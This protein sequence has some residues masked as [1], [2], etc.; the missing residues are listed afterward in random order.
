[1]QNPLDRIPSVRDVEAF[2]SEVCASYSL[3]NYVEHEV[4]EKG[5]EDCNIRLAT[6]TEAYL[7]KVFA[8][9]RKPGEAQR[10]VDILDHVLGANVAHP[11]L[12]A[13]S[14][15]KH[16]GRTGEVDHLVMDFLDGATLA[17]RSTSPTT[18]QLRQILREAA[19]IHAIDYAPEEHYDFWA[20]PNLLA[21]TSEI[22][23]HLDE[24][25]SQI[26]ESARSFHQSIPFG[27]LPTRLIHGD[28]VP[29][30]V[31]LTNDQ[32]VFLID[33]A[34][35]GVYPRIQELAQIAANLVHRDDLS[36][37]DTCELVARTYDEFVPLTELEQAAL[38]P[39]AVCA[40]AMEFVGAKTLQV[41]EGNAS[42]EIARMIAYGVERLRGICW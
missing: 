1:M 28:I 35:A 31:I 20:V 25:E 30:N 16:L 8:E 9:S 2:L 17:D 37:L 15:G 32:Q 22:E 42:E 27:Q 19:Q 24:I 5:S 21:T 14:D 13:V 33:F 36:L 18:P 11:V 23:G 6:D 3:G 7:V 4:I 10:C 40:A 29:S 41:K 38:Y 39:Y 12:H 26:V 34:Y